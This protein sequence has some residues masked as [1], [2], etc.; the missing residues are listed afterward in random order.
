MALASQAQ[1]KGAPVSDPDDE[2]RLR[3]N[4]RP[5]DWRNPTPRPRYD[6]VVLGGGPAGLA[7]AFRAVARGASVALIERHRLGGTCLH[8]GCVPS[9]SLLRTAQ[10]YA[11]MRS[12]E[13]FGAQ[14]PREITVDFARAMRRM[15]HV[16][17]RLSQGSSARSVVDA[18][19]DLF[20]AEGE[21]TR[22]DAMRLRGNTDTL[23]FGAG[24]LAMGSRPTIPAIPGLEEAG[25]RT[26]QNIFDLEELPERLVV[27]GGGPLG[28][29]LSQA[30]CRL[31]SRVTLVQKE[32][33]FL[34][35]EERDAAQLLSETLAREGIEIHLNTEVTSVRRENDGKHVE[36]ACDDVTSHLVA[37]EILVSTGQTPHVEG[38]GLDEAGV[39]WTHENGVQV[40]DFLRTTNPRIYAS[41]D[42]WAEHR[43]VHV[44]ESSA[45][46]VVENALFGGRERLSAIAIPWC[47]YTD[48]EIAHVG[49]YVRD[50]AERGL[51]ITTYTVPMHD[52]DRAVIDGEET[53]FVKVHTLLG[54]DVIVG[55]TVVARHAG[56]MIND[57]S[58]AI[59][60]KIGMRALARVV[61]AYPTQASAVTT[62]AAACVRALD[63]A[64]AAPK[65]RK[66]TRRA[67]SAT[68]R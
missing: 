58:L 10:V 2:L 21:L 30:F 57:L 22:P 1:K 42:V 29:E 34:R 49:T 51:A 14:A 24:V 9:K 63:A 62:A 52:V 11:E 20:F 46:I 16:R 31:G 6:V 45:D 68:S 17:A 28:C 67:P 61:R 40:D 60:A 41:G 23:R 65:K 48:P 13:R 43:F 8:T 50:A 36:L 25:Y 26:H 39:A 7:V 15:R 32:P 54:T 37:D 64:K 53:G 33:M 56:E 4:V 5:K 19:I 3:D 59:S 38:L 18:G 27:L 44:E 55:A 47:T 12:A 66:R 35:Q